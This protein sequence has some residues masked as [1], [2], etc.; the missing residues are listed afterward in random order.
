MHLPQPANQGQRQEELRTQ[1]HSNH[2]GASRLLQILIAKSMHLIWVLRCERVIQEKTHNENEIQARWFQA[3][4]TRLTE[5][6]IMATR[7]KRE[8]TFTKRVTFTWEPILSSNAD[9]PNNWLSNRE[10]LVGRRMLRPPPEE[11]RDS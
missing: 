3:I 1:G 11:G 5:E 8:Q 2:R 7:I 10:V 6:K 9:L 4:N